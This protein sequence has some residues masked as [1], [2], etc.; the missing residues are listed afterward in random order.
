MIEMWNIVVSL[1]C[2]IVL[3][4]G[5]INLGMWIGFADFKVDCWVK[6]NAMTP[7]S[8]SYLSVFEII[9]LY[10]VKIKRN[11]DLFEYSVKQQ[12]YIGGHSCPKLF[13]FIED[14][15]NSWAPNKSILVDTFLGSG[16]TLI[17]CE[18]TDRK[19]FGLEIDE[20]YCAVILERW[21][22]FTDARMPERVLNNT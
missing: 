14:I 1:Q 9:L 11:T 19:C 5:N 15:I 10:G 7:S 20:H 2:P 22:T 4:P 21:H 13:E 12:K 16:S 17:A 6:K 3:T 18:K 8:I